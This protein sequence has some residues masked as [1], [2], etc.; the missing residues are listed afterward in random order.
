MNCTRYQ[1]DPIVAEP[2]EASITLMAYVLAHLRLI[3]PHRDSV[4]DNVQLQQESPGGRY[5]AFPVF[6]SG[7]S[8][9]QVPMRLR[10]S[11]FGNQSCSSE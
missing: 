1:S 3:N 7:P 8:S 10:E 11:H 5:S 6:K 9:E 4:D 2:E